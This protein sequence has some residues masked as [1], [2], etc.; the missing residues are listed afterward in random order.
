MRLPNVAVSCGLLIFTAT[1]AAA[2]DTAATFP[3]KAAVTADDVYVR[4]GPGE[5]YYPTEKLK[6]G[7][8]VEVYRHDPGG[9]CAIRPVPGSFSWVSGR[10]LQLGSGRVATVTEDRVAARVGSR[11]SDIREVIQVRLHRGERVEVLDAKRN[12]P[13]TTSAVNTWYK[14][15]PPAG[16]FRWVSAKYLDA[17]FPVE[18]VRRTPGGDQATA[19]SGAPTTGGPATGN[20]ETGH[21]KGDS[22]IFAER[23]LGQSSASAP[24]V[25]LE[26]P[27]ASLPRTLSAEQF[28]AAV[29]EIDLDLSAMVVE[30]PTVW[31]FGELRQR[32]QSLLNQAETAVER[33]RA[34]LLVSKIARFDDIKQRY[35]HVAAMRSESQRT[36][37][38]LAQLSP[39]PQG[40]SSQY[41]SD[42]R[43]DGVG[44]LSRVNSPSDGAPQYALLDDSGRVRY[45]VTPAPGVNLRYYLGRQVGI[46]G[47]RGYVPEQQT[48]HLMAQHV[49]VLDGGT[50]R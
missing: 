18:G 1:F 50:L 31:Q 40:V 47:T 36:D 21:P 32:S 24:T 17:N 42:A 4:S 29:N 45:Y 14:I 25:V 3:Y 37:H 2:A 28:Q 30:E 41:D 27:A 33:G 46:N 22:P 6:T 44:K 16:E 9:W 7:D 12:G 38:Q 10:H 19:A 26:P 43:Y 39:R 8:Q 35:D 15:A 11:F 23:K 13:A 34:R 20:A 5:N 48:S 49:S